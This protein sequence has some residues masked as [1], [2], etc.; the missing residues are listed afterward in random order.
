MM[1]CWCPWLGSWR[2][3][4]RLR[5][6]RFPLS[7]SIRYERGPTFA[8]HEPLS[9]GALG[10]TG[11]RRTG[12]PIWSSGNG[13][14]LLSYVALVCCL[15]RLMLSCTPSTTSGLS[16]A[17]AVG[18]VVRVLLDMSFWVGLKLLMSGVFRHSNR[19]I[20]RSLFSRLAFL[21]RFLAI[22]TADSALPFAL[23]V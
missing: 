15:L 8:T 18:M 19:A 13:L 10:F 7:V 3:N 20:W 9:H 5:L 12:S 23:T 22:L 6:Y 21:T 11:W 1:G 14:A 17:S 2:M 4:F 16:N